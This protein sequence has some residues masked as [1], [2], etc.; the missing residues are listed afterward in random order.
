MDRCGTA[1]RA[2]NSQHQPRVGCMQWLG[3]T[4]QTE[5]EEHG[6][7]TKDLDR[8][9]HRHDSELDLWIVIEHANNVDD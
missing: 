1:D 9:S 7:E 8:E 6:T 2:P 5:C 3:G 4:L